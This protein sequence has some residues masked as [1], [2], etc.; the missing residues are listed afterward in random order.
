[1][2]R[3]QHLLCI[4]SSNSEQ[5]IFLADPDIRK[6]WSSVSQPNTH[7][8]SIQSMSRI[9]KVFNASMFTTVRSAVLRPA[10][11]ALAGKPG[12]AL[13]TTTRAQQDMA[14]TRQPPADVRSD[15]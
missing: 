10:G 5:G 8:L 4:C 14:S 7:S 15:C 1:V 6:F 12:R 2:S 13:T 3:C 11:P 9:T